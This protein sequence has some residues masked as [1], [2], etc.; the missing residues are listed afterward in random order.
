MTVMKHQDKEL[1]NMNEIILACVLWLK[2]KPKYPFLLEAML[3]LLFMKLQKT[4][5]PTSVP[6]WH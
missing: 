3:L 2:L 4:S 6:L 1:S 5:A